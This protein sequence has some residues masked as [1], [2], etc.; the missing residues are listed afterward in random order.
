MTPD[1]LRG[2]VGGGH[3]WPRPLRQPVPG[4]HLPQ[5]GRNYTVLIAP[6]LGELSAKLTEGA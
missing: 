3:A 6:P 4:C 1:L 2:N 5:R